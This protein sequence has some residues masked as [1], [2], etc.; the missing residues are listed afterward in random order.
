MTSLAQQMHQTLADRLAPTALEVLDESAA[1]AGHAGAKDVEGSTR[2]AIATQTRVAARV[3]A[4]PE[5]IVAR[6][7]DASLTYAQLWQRSEDLARGMHALGAQ[8]GARTFGIHMRNRADGGDRLALGQVEAEPRAIRLL[9]K[10]LWRGS[11]RS[12][13]F[14]PGRAAK[15]CAKCAGGRFAGRCRCPP[16]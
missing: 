3:A 10:P 7:G 2:I 15:R 9:S 13:L 4:H 14:G 16:A 11:I 1:H 6:C 5:R 8:V 12:R